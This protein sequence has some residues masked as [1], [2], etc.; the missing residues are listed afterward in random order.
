MQKIVM[1]LSTNEAEIQ[2]VDGEISNG[3]IGSVELQIIN[4]P[5]GW[6]NAGKVWATFIKNGNQYPKLTTYIASESRFVTM[7][8]SVIFK[9]DRSFGI[10]VYYIGNSD[11][12]ETRKIIEMPIAETG[13]VAIDVVPETESSQV[14][15][16]LQNMGV[17]YDAVSKAEENRYDMYYEAE[18]ISKE[19]FDSEHVKSRQEKYSESEIGRNE[20][21]FFQEEQRGSQYIAAEGTSNS[22]LG[23][24]SRWGKYKSAEQE[25]NNAFTDAENLRKADYIT[26]ENDRQSNESVRQTK[27]DSR[28]TNENQRISAENDRKSAEEIREANE[29]KREAA[30]NKI[31][32]PGSETIVNRAE[33]DAN[34]NKIHLTYASK[35]KLDSLIV[36]GNAVHR[37]ESDDMGNKIRLTYARKDEVQNN[38]NIVHDI[39]NLEGDAEIDAIPD[40][41]AVKVYCS[42]IQTYIVNYVDRAIGDIETSLENII[43]KY[44]LDG[45]SL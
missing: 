29:V 1:D 17:L 19:D 20:M 16:M 10:F 28:R 8:P 22:E 23:D 18:G 34:G 30:L 6:T 38:L 39:M 44:G 7:I 24:D 32:V 12:V 25:R 13:K 3:N 26:N 21:Y 41:R 33:A 2:S 37:A 15:Q 43:A 36:F 45:D 14:M 42:Y 27:E 40:A 11:Y 5:A 4:A 35:E 31:L 9:D